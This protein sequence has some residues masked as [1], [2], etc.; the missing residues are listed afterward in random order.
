MNVDNFQWSLDDLLKKSKENP[1]TINYDYDTRYRVWTNTILWDRYKSIIQTGGNLEYI[2]RMILITC[3]DMDRLIE[4]ARKE[5]NLDKDID[6]YH[7][8]YHELFLKT[9]EIILLWESEINE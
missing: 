1:M 9:K 3:N 7:K 8:R 4:R 5:F 6:Q 2:N